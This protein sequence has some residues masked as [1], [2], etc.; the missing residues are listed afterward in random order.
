MSELDRIAERMQTL[1]E[2]IEYHNKRYYE[3]DAPEIEDFEYDRLLHELIALEEQYPAFATPDSPTKHVGGKADAQ[4]TP[5]EHTVVMESLQD[6]FSE[7]DIRA[8]DKRVRDVVSSPVYIVERRVCTRLYP[9]RRTRGRRHHGKPQNGALHSDAHQYAAP[10]PRSARR[11]VYVEG[12][13]PRFD[14]KAGK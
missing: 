14:G 8:F 1:R 13:L 11:S 5:V 7:E 6:G 9:R 4:F 12:G 3:N 10:L 2:T